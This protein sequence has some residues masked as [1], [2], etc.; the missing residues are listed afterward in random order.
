MVSVKVNESSHRLTMAKLEKYSE[1]KQREIKKQV[2]AS[3][4]RIVRQAKKD[5]PVGADGAL[6]ASI[7]TMYLS[8][9]F[10]GIVFSDKKYAK[11]VELG[12]KPGSMP[13]FDKFSPL[14]RWVKLKLRIFSKWTGRVT[15]LVAK[16]I[17]DYGVKP[18][19]Y[20]FPAFNSERN[21]FDRAIK[22]IMQSV[23]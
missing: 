22:S 18:H 21:K 12:R 15:Y 23:R 5:C 8:K 20:L 9:G 4:E 3:S 14:F 7:R 1:D 11:E 13:A 10:T 6:R 19:P 17:R 16:H 2:F